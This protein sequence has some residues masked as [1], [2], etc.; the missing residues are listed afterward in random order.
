MTDT[1]PPEQRPVAGIIARILAATTFAF[2]AAMVKVGADLGLHPIEMIFWRFA[3]ALIPL[4]LWIALRS[5]FAVVKTTIP[6]AHLWRA[7]IGLFAM[8]FGYW[9]IS[10]LP[11][12]EATAISFAAPVFATMLSAI[13]M[14]EIVGWHRWAA[15]L[16]GFVGVL[17]VM[18]PGGSNLPMDGLI[19]ALISAFGVA[20]VII[21]IR[22]ISKTER[23]ITTVFWFTLLA[24]IGTGIAVPFFASS[25][26]PQEWMVLAAIA[27]FGGTAQMFLTA[28]LRVAPVV[29]VAPFDYIQLLWAVGF[30]WLIWSDVPTVATW[31]GSAIIIASGFYM[32]YRERQ[33]NRPVRPVIS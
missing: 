8:G 18:Q 24:A 6:L 3:L 16:L 22:Q 1:F 12:A 20:C 30:G 4:T 2:M 5:G 23:A 10:L 29:V 31:C 26:G 19:V 21:T 17:V 27:L 32:L 28:S 25:H 9:A 11:L 7:A 15:V 13:F 14:L 33:Y